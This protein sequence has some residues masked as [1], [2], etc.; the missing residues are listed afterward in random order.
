MIAESVMMLAMPTA[1]FGDSAPLGTKQNASPRP[2][3]APTRTKAPNQRGNAEDATM[4]MPS[5]AS[6]ANRAMPATLKADTR[7][8]LQSPRTISAL[9]GL[10]N[11]SVAQGALPKIIAPS[12]KTAPKSDATDSA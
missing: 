6:A 11:A 10:A 4:P 12:S 1:P 7:P 8:R 5:G 9:S 3:T 2:T